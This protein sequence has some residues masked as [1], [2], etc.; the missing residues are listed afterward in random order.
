MKTFRYTHADDQGD[1]KEGTLRAKNEAEAMKIL[2]D[3][4]LLVTSIEEEGS[5]GGSGNFAVGRTL[6]LIAVLTV[7]LGLGMYFWSTRAMQTQ[8]EKNRLLKAIE[9]GNIE[10]VALVLKEEPGLV[11]IP[12]SKGAYP[13]HMAVRT[14]KI[15]LVKA[16]LE[17]GAQPGTEGPGG[18]P[19]HWATEL[20]NSELANLLIQK[21][22]D[23]SAR[24]KDGE[25]PLHLAAAGNSTELVELLLEAGAKVA[26]PAEEGTPLH[27]AAEQNSVEAATLLLERGATLEVKDSTGKTPLHWAAESG[28]MEMVGLLK[29]KGADLSAADEEGNTAA[30]LAALAEFDDITRLL[31]P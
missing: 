29:D 6:G 20:G 3:K 1:K 16:V 10:K 19:L 4:G 23:V 27:Y 15:E 26:E 21:G 5:T 25:Q 13:I 31:T 30:Q 12:G 18:T 14:E 9:S 28:Q 2:S 11:S 22:A 7:V 8:E 24:N 17:A